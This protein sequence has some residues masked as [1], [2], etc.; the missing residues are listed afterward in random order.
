VDGKTGVISSYAGGGPA[1]LD[2]VAPTSTTLRPNHLAVDGHGN[3]YVSDTMNIRIRRIDA[4][5]NLITTVA[6]NGV[7]GFSGDGGAATSAKLGDPEAITLDHAGNLYISDSYS[8][9]PRVRR[10]RMTD[11]I[12]S[13]FAGNG[14][15]GTSGDGGDATSASFEYPRGLAVDETGALLI[16][17]IAGRVR[18]VK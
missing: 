3:L 2:N 10:V 18:R 16:G 6:G 11:N 14:T 1:F 7:Q 9:Q 4:S 15:F 13:T 17:D 12:I 5:Q 8:T